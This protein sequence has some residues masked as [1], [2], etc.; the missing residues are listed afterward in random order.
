[1]WLVT[2]LIVLRDNGGNRCYCISTVSLQLGNEI[3][4]SVN[5]LGKRAHLIA[6]WLTML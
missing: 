6:R 4:K 3:L 5:S 1:L 2:R